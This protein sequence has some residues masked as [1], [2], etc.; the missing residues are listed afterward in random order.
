VNK[1]SVVTKRSLSF[2]VWRFFGFGLGRFMG[3]AAS[4]VEVGGGRRSALCL[5]SPLHSYHT[6]N[7]AVG[8]VFGQNIGV[9]RGGCSEGTIPAD[10]QKWD[11]ISSSYIT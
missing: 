7:N 5:R 11:V 10:F 8:F 1:G 2:M 3:V 6:P 9:E 4:F